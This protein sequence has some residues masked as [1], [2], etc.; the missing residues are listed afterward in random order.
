MPRLPVLLMFF[1]PEASTKAADAL[2]RMSPPRREP[3]FR[4]RS[5]PPR[6]T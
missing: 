6:Q 2:R 3:I 5:D 4:Y 1:K